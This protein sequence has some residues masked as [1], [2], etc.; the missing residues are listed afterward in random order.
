V[1]GVG[2]WGQRMEAWGGCRQEDGGRKMKAGLDFWLYVSHLGSVP[3]LRMSLGGVARPWFAQCGARYPTCWRGARCECSNTAPSFSNT[4]GSTS[5]TAL[6]DT[7]GGAK[8]GVV[9]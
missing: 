2:K 9:M 6:S 5:G 8:R 3:P 4:I 1:S 7:V